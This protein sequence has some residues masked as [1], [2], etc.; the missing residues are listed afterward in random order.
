MNNTISGLYQ[1][2]E[3]VKMCVHTYLTTV[4]SDHQPPGFAD[5]L[6]GTIALYG[7]SKKYGYNLYLGSGHPLFHYMKPNRYIINTYSDVIDI[8]NGDYR[9]LY[10]KLECLFKSNKSFSTFTH[11][12]YHFEN[13][14]LTNWGNIE[15]DCKKYIKDILTPSIELETKINN[16]LHNVYNINEFKVIHIRFGDNYIHN[17]VYDENVYTSYYNKICNLMDKN[18][19]YVLITDSSAMGNKL[20]MTIPELYYWNNSKIHL[21]DVKNHPSGILDTLVDFFIMSRSTEIISSNVLYEGSVSGFSHVVS[22]LYN[23]TYTLF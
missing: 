12:F 6:R 10:Q 2:D 14:N 3:N 5:F 7:L 4:T 17:N 1:Q 16:I 20:K 23:I 15:E 11:S 13:G 19:K 22:L 9:D 21:G 8:T 18:V